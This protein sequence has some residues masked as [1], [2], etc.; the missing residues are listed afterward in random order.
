MIN[1]VDDGV[2]ILSV[3]KNANMPVGAIYISN[4]ID[5]SQATVGRILKEL[6]E[7]KY[8]EKVSN[9]GRIITNLGNEF[10]QEYN[11]KK[12]K[13]DAAIRLTDSY[14]E[15]SKETLI[16]ILEMRKILEVKAI[17][18]ACINRT[19]KQIIELELIL[20]QHIV[21]I[22]M[23]QLGNEQDLKLHLK[24]AEMS[25]NKTLY[26]LCRLLLTKKN[27]YTYFSIV[28]SDIKLAQIKHHEILIQAVKDKN[29][30]LAT[31]TM[32]DHI[33]RIISDVRIHLK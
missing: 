24:I 26:Y 18:L 22:S 1:K 31:K 12:S 23:D 11:D 14:N 5:M 20:K 19:K 28:T 7:R 10:L 15:T 9:K 4:E 8:I 2:K 13:V 32:N 27:A 33:D 3:I 17:E 29:I 16:E 6:E 25:N 30:E 21:E